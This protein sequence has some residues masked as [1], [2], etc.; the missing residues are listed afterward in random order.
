MSVRS[1]VG[2]PSIRA[3]YRTATQAAVAEEEVE[4]E[5]VRE[6]DSRLQMVHEVVRAEHLE[7]A[8]AVE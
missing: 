4:A 7:A 3:R 6:A 2:C 8:L 5:V 1:W